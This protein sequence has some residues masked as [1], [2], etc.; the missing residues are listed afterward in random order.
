MKKVNKSFESFLALPDGERRDA[1]EAVAISL[2]AL[3]VHVEKDFWV[4]LVL[5]MLYNRLPGGH[6]KLLFKGGTCLSKVFGLVQR[7][8]E[9]VDIVVHRDDLGFKDDRDPTAAD[10]L[11]N[12][13]R[14]AL[15]EELRAACSDYVLGDLKAALTDLID[16]T[17]EGC[18]VYPD[19]KDVSRQ[20]LYVDYPSLF[21]GDDAGYVAPLVKIEA[22]ARSALT[23]SLAGGVSP[24]IS[25]ELPDWSFEV[26]NIR[27]IAPERTYLEKLLILHGLHCGYRDEKRLPSDRG[28]ISRHYYDV[29]TVA[30]SEVGRAA[31]SDV[32]LLRDVRDHNL[33]AFRQAWKRLEEAAPGSM[34]LVPQPELIAVIERDYES[35]RSMIFGDAPD[36]EW[37]MERLRFAEAVVNGTSDR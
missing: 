14:K 16:D 32:G 28:R 18:R 20:T 17:A 5:D 35:M 4:C 23:P 10:N 3:A 11:S 7:F 33:V 15:F 36:I 34:R 27:A 31:M 2:S 30:A 12:K 13:K 22:G 29:A 25:A 8:S 6:P 26:E 9:D 19:D 24:Y 1:I 21:P 37:M